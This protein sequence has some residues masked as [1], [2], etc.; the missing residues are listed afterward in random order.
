MSEMVFAQRLADPKRMEHASRA[1]TL[2]QVKKTAKIAVR[3]FT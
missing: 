3:R 1:P 2:R